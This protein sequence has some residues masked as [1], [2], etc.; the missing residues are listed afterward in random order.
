MKEKT[1]EEGTCQEPD[2]KLHFLESE[3]EDNEKNNPDL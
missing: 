3:D 1:Q 2:P